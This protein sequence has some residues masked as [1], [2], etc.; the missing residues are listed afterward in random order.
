MAKEKRGTKR[1]CESCGGKFY[2]L[3]RDPI[4]CPTCETPF[5]IKKPKPES[6]PKVAFSKWRSQTQ[7]RR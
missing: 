1:L 7:S 3:G 2:D 4:V 5:I 6:K